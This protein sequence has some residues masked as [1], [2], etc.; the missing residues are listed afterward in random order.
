MPELYKLSCLGI[1]VFSLLNSTLL[2]S[3]LKLNDNSVASVADT[4]CLKAFSTKLI[5]NKGATVS[6]GLPSGNLLAQ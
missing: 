6:C 5:N 1:I 4:P 3:T 2:P